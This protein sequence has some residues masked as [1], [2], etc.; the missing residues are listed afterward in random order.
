MEII[1]LFLSSVVWVT[2]QRES[3][4]TPTVKYTASVSVTV[5]GLGSNTELPFLLTQTHVGRLVIE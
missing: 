4:R 3:E 1:Q 5:G 2:Q